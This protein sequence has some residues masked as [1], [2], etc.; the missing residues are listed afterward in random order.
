MKIKF[1]KILA[2]GGSALLGY[3]LGLSL[4]RESIWSLLL[5]TLPPINDRHLPRF[6][7]GI[8]GAFIVATLG[9]LLYTKLVDKCSIR[10]CKKQYTLGMIALI[11]LPL[12]TMASFRV[13]AVNF[14]KN[15]EA[16]YPTGIRLR[17]E[18]PS[19][20]FEISEGSAILFGKSINSPRSKDENSLKTLGE[21]LKQLEIIETSKKQKNYTPNSEATMWID[22][23]YKGNW[24]SKILTWEKD[25]FQ[26][27]SRDFILY[28]GTELEAVLEDYNKQLG[29]LS[30]YASG[31]IVHTSMIDATGD[32]NLVPMS[33]K[34]LQ[35]L[36][37]SLREDNKISPEDNVVS[38][39][40]TILKERRPITKKD[41]NLYVFSL[42]SQ[43]KEIVELKSDILLENVILYDAELKLAWFEGDYYGI[44]LSPIL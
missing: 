1:D 41:T 44:D 31:E 25:K 8:M 11:L 33:Q 21:A 10:K 4:F 5:S 37:N 32:K 6:Y 34:D 14:V 28:Q 3:Y 12:L 30:N 20:A 42:Q 27:A 23:D 38:S 36:I 35:F 39:F 15:A 7:T 9:Y 19:I 29:T 40:E 24:Y 17:F 18:E 2:L 26:E 16:T 43:P 22:Y 13:Q